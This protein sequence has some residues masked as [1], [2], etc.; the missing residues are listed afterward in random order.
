MKWFNAKKQVDSLPADWQIVARSYEQT[1]PSMIK[2]DNHGKYKRFV[3]EMKPV[4]GFT[5]QLIAYKE[6]DGGTKRAF[7]A[8]FNEKAGTV[9][10]RKIS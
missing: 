5:I 4:N 10:E 9:Y 3:I 2:S 7:Y 1:N 6:L 8:M